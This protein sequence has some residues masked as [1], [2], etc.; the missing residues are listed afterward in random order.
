[1]V[2]VSR[3]L[4]SWK[5]KAE[6]KTGQLQGREGEASAVGR[7]VLRPQAGPKVGALQSPE[8]ALHLRS[9]EEHR[10]KHNADTVFQN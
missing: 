8:N 9:A 2:L 4:V 10:R 3:V 5:P 6:S 1:M 7:S